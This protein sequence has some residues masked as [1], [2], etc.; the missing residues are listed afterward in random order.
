MKILRVKDANRTAFDSSDVDFTI[1]SGSIDLNRIELI[2]DAFSLIGNGKVDFNHQIDLNFYSIMGRGR[3]YIPVV[4]ELYRAGSQ[5]VLWI[6]V[7][8]TCENPT[9]HRNVLPQLNDTIQVLLQP[10]PNANGPPAWGPADVNLGPT[11][12]RPAYK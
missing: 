3:W 6:N 2:G 9:T 8:G 11:L 5:Q 12:T 4:S 7:D 10:P 1:N